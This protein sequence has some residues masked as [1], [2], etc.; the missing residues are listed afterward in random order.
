MNCFW[1]MNKIKITLYKKA[2]INME[3][4]IENCTDLNI[5]KILEDITFKFARI[6]YPD[7]ATTCLL[8]VV[9][10]L[11]GFAISHKRIKFEEYDD[12]RNVRN[13]NIFTMNFAP[14]GVG[15]D[16]LYKNIC[17]KILKYIFDFMKEKA[18]KHIE[19]LKQKI[20]VDAEKINNPVEKRRYIKEETAKIRNIEYV[21]SNGTPEGIYQDAKAITDMSIGGM[22]VSINELG[23]YIS[24]N[25]DTKNQLLN[26]LYEAFDGDIKSKLIKTSNRD[27]NLSNIVVNALLYGDPNYFREKRINQLVELM[28]NNGLARRSFITFQELEVLSIQEDIIMGFKQCKNAYYLADKLSKELFEIFNKIPNG[29]IYKLPEIISTSIFLPYV[30]KIKTNYNATGN[31][32]LRKVIKS[33]ELKVLLLSTLC[34]S[35]NHPNRLIIEKEDFEQGISITEFL[36]KDFIKFYN[37]MYDRNDSYGKFFEFLTKNLG[38][39]FTKTELVNNHYKDFGIKREEF[40]K[41]HIWDSTIAILQEIAEMK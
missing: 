23:A 24:E 22:L 35:L 28:M 37:Y 5:P 3:N 21:V 11:V 29:A 36:S 12:G 26:I 10:T 8:G 4:V 32:M 20:I 30:N 40:R 17:S 1:L 16:K 33:K 39:T 41:K 7:M 6:I 9:L 34:A 14:S 13:F 2:R 25:D 31:H 38:K 19:E 18:E 27:E 15:K